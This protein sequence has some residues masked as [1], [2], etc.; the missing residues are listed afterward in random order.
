MENL[1]HQTKEKINQI[2]KMIANKIDLQQI[3]KEKFSSKTKK[4]SWLDKNNHYFT[5][6]E[7]LYLDYSQTL[8]IVDIDSEEKIEEKNQNITSLIQI[9]NIEKLSINE[10]LRLILSDETLTKLQI[11]LNGP[12]TSNLSNE[13]PIEYTK[14][15]DIKIKNCRMSENIYNRLVKHCQKNNLTITSV[16]NYLIDSYLKER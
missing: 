11:L 13:I 16:L 5:Y 15:T 1:N 10:R 2:K 6:D 3:V 7:L 9:K 12:Q 8:E 14:L 4:N